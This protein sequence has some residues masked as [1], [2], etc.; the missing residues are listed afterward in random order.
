VLL[1]LVS[2]SLFYAPSGQRLADAS[3]YEKDLAFVWGEAVTI[4]QRLGT[5]ARWGFLLMGVALLMTTELGVLDA[6]SR[7]SMD[8]VKVNWLRES[9]RWTESRLYYV[10]LWTTIAIGTLILLVGMK[11][12]PKVLLFELTASL[13]GAVMFLYCITLLVLNRKALPATIRLRGWRVAVMLW[14]V[15]FFGFF[16]LMAGLA[17]LGVDLSALWPG[18]VDSQGP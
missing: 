1:T 3:Q 15:S 18:A 17:A 12:I 9:R 7:I 13:N 6:T 8:I 14:A 11:R 2:Y 16:A 5:F 10:F 4:G